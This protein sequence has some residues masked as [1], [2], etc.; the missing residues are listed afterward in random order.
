MSG[1]IQFSADDIQTWA[2]L[3]GDYNPIHFDEDLARGRGL[4][5]VVAHGMLSLLRLKHVVSQT[6]ARPAAEHVWVKVK[7]RF[8]NPV[9]RAVAHQMDVRSAGQKSRFSLTRSA[10]GLAAMDGIMI[11]TTEPPEPGQTWKA[12]DVP[13]SR[14]ETVL[15]RFR[16]SY[17]EMDSAWLALDCLLFELLLQN[18][19]PF[20]LCKELG[21]AQDYES[22]S[23]MMHA[24][25]T[26]QSSHSLHVCADLMSANLDALP[27]LL[28]LR[29]TVLMPTVSAPD[30]SQGFVAS[31]QM[32]MHSPQ[33]L[34]IQSDVGLV[35]RTLPQPA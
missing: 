3:V 7:A 16:D 18:E 11:W 24:A 14:F 22:Q 12:F 25:L 17:P 15:G 31:C 26:V 4:E 6:M 13:D 27:Q 35:V 29:C 5:G 32:Q 23:E 28:P 33:S 8:R 21:L 2:G 19:I 30:A 1:P 9:L 10:D 20:Q 34:L